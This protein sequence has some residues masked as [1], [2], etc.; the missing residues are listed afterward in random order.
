M[1]THEYSNKQF[2]TYEEC[3]DELLPEIDEDDIA[4]EM[5]LGVP[6]IISRFLHS[7]Q[8]GQP[9]N[10]WFQEQID[11]AITCVIDGLITEYEDEEEEVD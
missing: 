7:A 3:A 5:G 10:E 1:Y 4:D 9:F 2:K 8:Y 6:E 11:S